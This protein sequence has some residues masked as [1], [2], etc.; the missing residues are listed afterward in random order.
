MICVFLTGLPCSGKTTIANELQKRLQPRTVQVLDG[1][2]VRNNP[3]SLG[4][5]FDH[6]DRSNNICRVGYIAK[7]L[8]DNKVYAICAL[9]SPIAEARDKVRNYFGPNKFIEVHLN[10]PVDVCKGRNV[11]G[12]WRKAEL[13]EIKGFTGVDDNYEE[14]NNPELTLDTS[15]LDLN[16]CVRQIYF[17]VREFESK[18]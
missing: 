1:D 5:S 9:V 3:I 4:L 11:K 18:R 12:M 16:E 6:G 2:D 8:T 14:P 17:K 15:E 13:G 7:M 10:T